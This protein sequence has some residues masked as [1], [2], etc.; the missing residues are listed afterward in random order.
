M[1]RDIGARFLTESLKLESGNEARVY[2]Q[3]HIA[4]V[5]LRHAGNVS[6]AADEMGVG[7]ATLNRWIASNSYIAKSLDHARRCGPA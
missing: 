4:S 1:A 3:T 5:L 7:R 6:G 2:A